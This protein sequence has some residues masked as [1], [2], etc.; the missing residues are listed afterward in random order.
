MMSILL[1][2][3]CGAGDPDLPPAAAEGRQVARDNGCAACH[4]RNGEGGVGPAWQGLMGSE[5]ELDDGTTVTADR[6]YLVRS[7]TDPGA[8]IVADYKVRMPD[9]DLTTTEID[10]VIAYLEE[11]SP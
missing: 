4:G 7:I 3:A 1:L 5:V 8:D 11:I 10:A 9:N 2:G 6:D